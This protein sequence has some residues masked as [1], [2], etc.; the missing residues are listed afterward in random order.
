MAGRVKLGQ[1]QG[2]EWRDLLTTSRW[3]VMK[4]VLLPAPWL[5][6]SLVMAAEEIYPAA[7]ALSFIFFLTG[8]RLNRAGCHYS[9]GLSRRATDIAMLALSVMML[10]S[11]HAVQWNQR[12]HRHCLAADDIEAMGA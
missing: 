5:A 2:I 12:H 7:L 6:G 11:M 8:L 4:E 10:G 1:G 3:E 9:L